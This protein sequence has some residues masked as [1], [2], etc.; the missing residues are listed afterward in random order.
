[1]DIPERVVGHYA[2]VKF[3]QAARAAVLVIG[4]DR[5]TRADLARVGCFHFVAAARLSQ[6]IADALTVPDARALFETIPPTALAIP[7]VGLTCL[8][9]LGAA[10]QAKGIGGAAPLLQ[11]VTR[12]ADGNAAH[13]LVTF[14]TL[15]ARELADQRGEHKARTDRTA[16]RRDRAHGI[17]VERHAR[18]S[19]PASPARRSRA[20]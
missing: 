6:K 4:S 1:M 3:Q 19:A 10:F 5:F 14:S 7:G 17:R 18:R 11:Y 12:H 8:L 20:S 2:A 9:V 13:T 16:A 15:K